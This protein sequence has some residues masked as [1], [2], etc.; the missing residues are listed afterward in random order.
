MNPLIA[1]WNEVLETNQP[2][3]PPALLAR[4][5]GGIDA[6][7]CFD[8]SEFQRFMSGLVVEHF[9]SELF[10]YR[11]LSEFMLADASDRTNPVFDPSQH[12]KFEALR[13]LPYLVSIKKHITDEIGR[14][15]RARF[16][17]GNI[18]NNGLCLLFTRQL[19]SSYLVRYDLRNTLPDI[20]MIERFDDPKGLM[21]IDSISSLRKP[22][23]RNFAKAFLTSGHKLVLQSGILT[24]VDRR[25][26]SEVF[27]PTIDTLYLADILLSIPMLPVTRVLEVGSGSGHVIS[28]VACTLESVQSCTFIDINPKSIACTL[29]NFSGNTK[30]KRKNMNDIFGVVGPFSN[31]FLGCRFDLVVCNP[32][33][34]ALPPEGIGVDPSHYTE[35]VA[36]T[37]LMTGLLEVL[38]DLLTPNGK[39]LLMTSSTSLSAVESSVPPNF[40]VSPAYRGSGL[41]VPFDVEA[42]LGD[43]NWINHLVQKKALELR[44]DTYW[45]ELRPIWVERRDA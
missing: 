35:A 9:G 21:E 5:L 44:E 8:D 16:F 31:D 6:L 29:R 24:H 37:E 30:Y 3:P 42:A 17:E 32:P 19:R 34:I 13:V 28:T 33:Y 40:D 22:M 25:I 2:Y 4:H 10:P 1:I 38:D 11:S 23:A 39:L 45:H 15:F 7:S 12:Q 20:Q 41:K 36:G 43:E 18:P 26:D 27:G 14:V